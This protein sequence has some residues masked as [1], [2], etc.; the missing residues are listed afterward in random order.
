MIQI[1]VVVAARKKV[2]ELQQKNLL[3]LNL[4]NDQLIHHHQRMAK[5]K[6]DKYELFMSSFV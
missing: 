1:M 4:K 3:Q 6:R 2:V 5:E